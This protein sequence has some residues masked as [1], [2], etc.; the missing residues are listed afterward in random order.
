MLKK[1]G[2]L[3]LDSFRGHLTKEVKD[4]IA[5]CNIDLVVIPGGMT[6]QLQAMYVVVNKQFKTLDN[7]I[8]TIF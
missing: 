2:M 7:N 1:R 5:K 4:V 8:M 3:V 6:S